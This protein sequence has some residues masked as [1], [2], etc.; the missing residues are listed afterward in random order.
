MGLQLSRVGVDAVV[1]GALF[2]WFHGRV[3]VR[4]EVRLVMQVERGGRWMDDLEKTSH[5]DFFH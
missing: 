2:L 5:A 1:D 4:G 3:G